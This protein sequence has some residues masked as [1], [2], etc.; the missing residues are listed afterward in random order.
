MPVIMLRFLR[1]LTKEPN[2]SLIECQP[3]RGQLLL[4][5]SSER[6]FA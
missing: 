2:V 1:V 6:C 5:L 4:K 3:E